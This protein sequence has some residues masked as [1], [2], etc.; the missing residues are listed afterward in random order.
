MGTIEK[1]IKLRQYEV[2]DLNEIWQLFY[3]TIHSVNAADYTE[4]QL[5]AWATSNIDTEKWGKN[6]ISENT[7]VAIFQNK[8]VGFCDIN[9]EGYINMFYVHKDYIGQG[10]GKLMFNELFNRVNS[11]EL[12]TFASITAKIFFEKLGFNVIRENIIERNG[13][14]LRNYLM[15]RNRLI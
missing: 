1:N 10:I 6:A 9:Q 4:E 13:V 14:I 8:I 7:V 3:D 2:T 15:T 5:S 11:K 12:S